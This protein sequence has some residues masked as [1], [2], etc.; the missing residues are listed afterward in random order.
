[1]TI[2]TGSTQRRRLGNSSEQM[3][4][5]PSPQQPEPLITATAKA[6]IGARHAS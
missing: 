1:V 5:R 4:H 2:S 3:D 6:A